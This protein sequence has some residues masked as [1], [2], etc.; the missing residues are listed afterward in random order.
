MNALKKTLK[1]SV[2]MRWF[3]LVLIS[4]IFF[5]MYWFYDVFSS[6]KPLVIK[7]LGISN[8]TFGMIYS[9]ATW[10]NVLGMIIVGGII[11][12]KWGIRLA[13]AVFGALT[14]L[15]AALVAVGSTDLITSDSGTKL[16]LF[17]IGRILFGSGVEIVCVVVSR[18]VVKWFKGKE[19]ALAMAINV[20]FGRIG[21]ALAISLSP[22]IA[23]A[24]A[25]PA[26]VFAGGLV[27]AGFLML[28]AYLVFDVKIDR[29]I[30]AE[31][32][33][34]EVFRLSDLVKLITNP[35]FLFIALLCVTFYSAVFPFMQ[36]AP[37]LL[38]H[39]YG[40]TMEMPSF[41]GLSFW[42]KVSQYFSYAPT[43]G[44]QVASLIPLGTILFTPIF[45][46]FVDRRGRAATLMIIGGAL[47]T[48]AHLSLSIFNHVALGYAGL[49]SLGIAFSLVPAAMWP[50]VAKIVAENRLGTAYA[51]MFTIQNF[52]L[53]TIPI[54][55][56]YVL[57][58]TNTDTLNNFLKKDIPYDYTWP[59]FL[60]AILGVVAIIMAFLLKAADRRQGYGLE[61]PSSAP[62]PADGK[63]ATDEAS[64]DTPKTD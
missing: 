53:A 8:A 46:T 59:I 6:L 48:F 10:A 30:E 45:G 21:S 55:I 54:F 18:T 26:L 23:G 33:E 11:L 25:G 51:S 42:D 61:L 56:G 2:A 62:A 19:L 20:A 15:G 1:D 37:D 4:G 52:G 31:D 57:D 13:S 28:L 41:A 63:A 34:E 39:K 17:V 5:G 60:L 29:Q 16:V 22:S 43:N 36:Y 50:S 44:P 9:A 49:L 58:K 38:H 7:E 47:L 64:G 14:T 27:G 24:K 40:F 32:A 3:V 35:S 12:D